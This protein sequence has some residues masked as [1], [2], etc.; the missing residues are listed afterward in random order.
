MDTVALGDGRYS[1]AGIDCGLGYGLIQ[2]K[3]RR[4]PNSDEIQKMNQVVV[5]EECQ[6]FIWMI[7]C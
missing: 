3:S 4:M 6:S 1:D 5:D 2:V 7:V